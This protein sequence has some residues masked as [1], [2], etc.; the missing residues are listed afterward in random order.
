MTLIPCGSDPRLHRVDP[1]TGYARE[2]AVEDS[3]LDDYEKEIRIRIGGKEFLVPE[4]NTL[5][6]VLQHLAAEMSY[7][8]FCWNGECHNCL[9]TYRT[10]HLERQ[11]L[12]CR[13]K[14]TDGMEIQRLPEGIELD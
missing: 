13:V 8:R 9:F 7:H 12:G 3:L 14:V 10:G 2:S 5:L 6:R 4:N 1:L 11:G